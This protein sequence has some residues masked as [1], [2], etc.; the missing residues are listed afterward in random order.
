M[1]MSS[2]TIVGIAMLCFA[3]ATIFITFCIIAI[4]FREYINGSGSPFKLAYNK[5]K[6]SVRNE[7]EVKSLS[8]NR[9]C[10]LKSLHAY[11]PDL[12]VEAER[13]SRRILDRSSAFEY[14]WDDNKF[15]TTSKPSGRFYTIPIFYHGNRSDMGKAGGN[16]T[17]PMKTSNIDGV[18]KNYASSWAGNSLDR[19]GYTKG[20]LKL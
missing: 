13:D 17:E 19:D 20:D 18:T 6:P 11:K 10:S 16:F 7:N 5:Q 4:A 8:A 9:A 15:K 3:G 14:W 1:S 2:W 12:A